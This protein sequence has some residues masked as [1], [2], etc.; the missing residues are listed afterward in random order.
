MS[1]LLRTLRQIENNFYKDH[2]VRRAL[3]PIR[4]QTGIDATI[5]S[6][7]RNIEPLM[8]LLDRAERDGII[9]AAET[10]ALDFVDLV[11]ICHDPSATSL[12]RS[13]KPSGRATSTTPPHV[14][15]C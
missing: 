14:P 3:R 10:D 9:T 6:T 7:H 12:P 2:A 5:F 4:R 8:K 13:P 11:L 1:D 15:W